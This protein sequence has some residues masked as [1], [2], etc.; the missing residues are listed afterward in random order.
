MVD[1]SKLGRVT[2]G[3]IEENNFDEVDDSRS[4][5]GHEFGAISAEIDSCQKWPLKF[6][7]SD[8]SPVKIETVMIQI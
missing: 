2:P 7:R 8:E 5:R 4:R 6:E 1:C 3:N